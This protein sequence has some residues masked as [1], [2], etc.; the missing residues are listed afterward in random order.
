MNKYP[1]SLRR[2]LALE[3]WRLSENIRIEQHELRQLFWECT[4]RCN[5]NCR[6]CGSDCKSVASQ[7]DMPKEDFLRVL[8]SVAAHTNPN[9]VFVV[10]TGG[11]P[12]MRPDL[13][14]CGREIY[15]K[16]FPWGIVTN[17]LAMTEKRLQSLVGAGMHTITVSLDGLED[18]HN[19]MRGNPQSFKRAVE[20]IRI[21]SAE[22]RIKS[23]V[24]TCVNRRSIKNL[25]A[26]KEL[27][28]SLGVTGWRLF[29]IFPAGR[30]AKEDDLQLTAEEHRYLMEYIKRNRKEEK[31]ITL[32]YCCEGFMGDYEGD[33]RD[34]FYSCQAGVSVGSVLIDGSIGACASIRADYHQGNIYKDDF[35]Y[36]WQNRYEVYRN[37]EWMRKGICAE[38]NMFRYCQGNGMHLRDNNGN[39][40]HC[41]LKKLYEDK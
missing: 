23:D 22:K 31:R 25:D 41:N 35:W 1:L 32:N 9:K 7:P 2:R 19:F 28:V 14:A 13:E 39:L 30:A 26:I 38:C 18:E 34:H 17:G 15:K 5:L 3:A 33:I 4:L 24:V 29:T 20:A 27:L 6:H 21:I 16:G 36:V 12:L 8:D 11:E 10:I 37:R 40:L